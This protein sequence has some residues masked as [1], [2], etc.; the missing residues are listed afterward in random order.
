MQGALRGKRWI[1]GSSTHDC[2]LGCY[3]Y[4]KQQ[5]L[6]TKVQEGST[7]FD[8]GANVGFYTLLASVL[9][10]ARGH[11]YSFEPVRRNLNYLYRH[12]GL[13]NISNVSVFEV[14]VSD[15]SGT[16]SFD[17]G[18]GPSTG[19]ISPNGEISVD[20]VSLDT[21]YAEGKIS[22][23]DCIKIDV[24][25]AEYQVLN[26]A[27]ALLR[28]SHP[29][30]FLAIHGDEERRACCALLQTLGYQLKSLDHQ[31]ITRTSELLA[32]YNL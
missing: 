20:V 24:E 12:L 17:S 15:H 29:I 7:F 27:L 30:I 21:L 18:T 8:I 26:G 1:I 19:K 31:E 9:A 32:E 22:L 16:S 4:D 5:L 25:G 3:E 10:G 23:P 28:R 6:I 14:A 11:I 13:N 2:W